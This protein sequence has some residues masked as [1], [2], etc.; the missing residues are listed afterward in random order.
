[1]NK[2]VTTLNDSRR[3]ITIATTMVTLGGAIASGNPVTIAAAIQ[4]AMQ[5][6]QGQ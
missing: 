6:V 3:V 1:V 2:A 5:T 4:N